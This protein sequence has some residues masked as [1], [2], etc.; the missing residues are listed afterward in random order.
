MIVDGVEYVTTRDAAERLA[1]D[2]TAD[3]IRDWRRLGL[4]HP[5][6]D[7]FDRPVRMPS[8]WGPQYVYRW[9]EVVEAEH[10]TRTSP[11]G[12]KRVS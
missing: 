11:D 1:P 2:V 3:V 12:R 8:P 10:R 5:V 4:I 7:Q 9:D 6:L